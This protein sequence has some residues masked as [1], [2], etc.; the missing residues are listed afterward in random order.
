MKP[1]YALLLVIS[2]CLSAKADTEAT[3]PV[4]S[5]KSAFREW[6]I[7]MDI[8]VTP[9]FDAEDYSAK[10]GYPTLEPYF[11][12]WRK[13]R[14]HL[15]KAI[16]LN[17]Y[18]PDAY[19][20]L[21]RSYWEVGDDLPKAVELYSKA[22][23]LDPEYGQMLLDR[24]QVYLHMDDIKKSEEDLARLEALKSPHAETLR[25]QIAESK[26]E[27]KQDAPDKPANDDKDKP[28]QDK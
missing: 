7:A 27:G 14:P 9:E 21:A 4:E 28:Q 1:I 5:V 17:P 11:K 12:R 8:I 16:S 26:L 10:P 6:R 15:E 23:E 24:G 2:L 22:L 13:T 25:G 18:F 3:L 19:A 20:L